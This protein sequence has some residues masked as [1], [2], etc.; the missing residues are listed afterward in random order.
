MK[1]IGSLFVIAALALTACGG[2]EGPQGPEEL[3]CV[4][5][6]HNTV[7]PADQYWT[8]LRDPE[9]F[10]VVQRVPGDEN[11][12]KL[13]RFNKSG[14]DL[15]PVTVNLGFKAAG[16]SSATDH[17]IAVDESG[18]TV[19]RLTHQGEIIASAAGQAPRS[20]LAIKAGDAIDAAAWAEDT[21]QAECPTVI[22]YG[23][24]G[25]GAAI[26]E[27]GSIR[28]CAGRWPSI[29]LTVNGSDLLIRVQTVSSDG[30]SG[31]FGLYHVANGQAQMVGIDPKLKSDD[32][33]SYSATF[34]APAGS[35][36][37]VLWDAY[38][39]TYSVEEKHL[40]Y[41]SSAGTVERTVEM[42]HDIDSLAWNGKELAAV[43]NG[44]TYIGLLRLDLEGRITHEG[45]LI[46][47]ELGWVNWNRKIILISSGGNYGVTWWYSDMTGENGEEIRQMFTT[48]HDC[49]D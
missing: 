6:M 5:G 45:S 43:Y 23:Q 8:T 13:V 3:Q 39:R 36:F 30:I 15:D 40:S 1:K 26:A 37:A 4:I 11:A 12:A 46:H 33:R 9:G 34:I 17:V 42:K 2:D 44:S 24:I 19:Q 48:V 14:G 28:H 7:H 18:G 49:E 20:R 32:G 35:G 16:F 47:T 22:R 25:A 41:I 27:T 10:A 29:A 21:G 38:E 31:D